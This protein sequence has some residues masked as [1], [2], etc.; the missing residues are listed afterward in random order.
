M[1]VLSEVA[2][3]DFYH[4]PEYHVMAER[5][6]EGRGQLF[7]HRRGGALIALPL[8]IARCNT[9][10]GLEAVSSLDATSVYGYAGPLSSDLNPP[11]RTVAAFQR[12]LRDAL[13]DLD[14]TTL[15]TRLHPLLPQAHLIAGLGSTIASGTTVSVDLTASAPSPASGFRLNHIRDVR[16]L[17]AIGATC[18]LDTTIS[19]EAFIDLYHQTM[20]RVGASRPYFFDREYFTQLGKLRGSHVHLFSC[21]LEGEVI[22]AGL[23]LACRGIVQYHLGAV[24]TGYTGLGSMKLILDTVRAWGSDTGMHVL[25]LG[26]GRGA[27]EDSLFHFKAGFS[28]RRHRYSTWR[29]ILDPTQYDALTATKTKW[30]EAH[31]LRFSADDHFPLYRTPTCGL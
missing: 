29:W 22:A 12:S 28:D 9:I 24:R 4:L 15:F 30:N 31:R 18:G 27:Q 11:A 20:H 17:R 6:G 7:V 23:F 19:L 1:A 3:Y 10:D 26:G 14:V 25:H 16:R 2:Q 21:V 13:G 8:L 5:A